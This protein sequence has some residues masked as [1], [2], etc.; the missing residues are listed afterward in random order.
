MNAS[1]KRQFT[2]LVVDD[3]DDLLFA[4]K[5]ALEMLGDFRVVTASDGIAG[6]THIMQEPPDCAVIDVVM[7]GLNGNQLVRAL[8]GDPETAEIPLIILSALVQERDQQ[9]GALSGADQYLT[10]PLNAS[11]LVA[12]IQ[13]AQHLTVAD[14]ATRLRH[15]SEEPTT[16]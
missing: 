4:V 8:R 7:P 6:L 12:A 13:H 14:R 2:V 10:K 11:E 15:L 3:N 16:H 5:T 9:T 1:P